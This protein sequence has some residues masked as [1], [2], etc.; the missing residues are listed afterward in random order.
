MVLAMRLSILGNQ[1]TSVPLKEPI[2]F[3]YYSFNE[4]GYMMNSLIAI[5]IRTLLKYMSA[6]IRLYAIATRVP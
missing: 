1:V 6:G 5:L 4:H 2:Q 3:S